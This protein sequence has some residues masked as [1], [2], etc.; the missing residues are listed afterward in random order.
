MT[1][2]DANLPLGAGLPGVPD[3][4]L[5]DG[6]GAPDPGAPSL[7]S[8]LEAEAGD[9]VIDELTGGPAQVRGLDALVQALVLAVE[10]QSGSDRL[11][12]EFGF[13]RLAVGRYALGVPARKEYIR[14]QL[15]R[16]L[17]ADRRVRDVREVFF[18]DD[19]RF[20]ELRPGLDEA[21][22]ERIVEAARSRRSYTAYAVVETAAGS[23]LTLKSGGRLD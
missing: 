16:C 8:S 11:N 5:S 21:A 20:L 4:R 10:T 22:H 2:F 7:G 23:T 1:L 3:F 15:V 12:T 18:E 19:P 13:D 9:L 17:S 6:T 14:M